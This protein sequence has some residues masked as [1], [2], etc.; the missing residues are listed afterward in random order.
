MTPYV[1]NSLIPYDML[2]DT[3]I[4]LVKYIQFS[5]QGDEK[6][7]P[8][9]MEMTDV[10]NTDTL[11]YM[12]LHRNFHNPLS[13][14]MDD[15]SMVTCNPDE[16]LKSFFDNYEDQILRLSTSTALFSM[17]CKSLF[18]ANTL[19]FTVL[20][21]NKAQEDDLMRRLRKRYEVENIPIST[22][23]G[24]F[25]SVK[26]KEYGNFYIKVVWDIDKYKPP[27]EGKNI[28]IANYD[29]NKEYNDKDEEFM[30]LPLM[31]VTN[32]YMSTNKI[33]FIDVYPE[34]ISENIV[35]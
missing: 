27:M 2:V 30:N 32:K 34:S 3:D 16:L 20:C 17:V 25:S 10:E 12:A 26:T 31:E 11:K 21:K 14:I 33:K 5:C 6:Y 19:K 13:I 28:I 4:G 8:G 1:I 7:L 9:V 24:D 29:F 35:G 22:I 15:A 18:V 23:I